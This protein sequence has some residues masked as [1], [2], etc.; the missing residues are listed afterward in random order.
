M[1]DKAM[2]PMP[3][4]APCLWFDGRALE[5]A[6]FYISVFPNSHIDRILRS[7]IDTPGAKQGEPLL[8]EFTLAGKQYQALNG[9][10][11]HP[12]NDAISL[13]VLCKDQA[14]VDRFW[15]ALTADGGKPVQCSWLKDKFGVAWQI[16]P[17]ALPRLL[18]DKDPVKAKRVMEAMIQ[19]VKIDV[20][21]LQAAYN[22]T[23]AP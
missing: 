13:S 16:V 20:A 21:T 2:A 9:G 1:T 7:S 18:H 15:E 4:I 8:I 14:D 11:H 19:M 22:G 23:V 17:E 10:P 12:F 5:A 6:E 3:T